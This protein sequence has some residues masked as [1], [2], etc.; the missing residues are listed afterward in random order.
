MSPAQPEVHRSGRTPLDPDHVDTTVEVEPRAPAEEPGGGPVPDANRPGRHPETEQD[1]P[2]LD[3]F[4]ERFGTTP[5]PDEPAEGA[6]DDVDPGNGTTDPPATGQ[7]EADDAPGSGTTPHPQDP[8]EG[9][10]DA[11][12]E[13]LSGE[14]SRPDADARSA[15]RGSG[16][17]PGSR[18]EAAASLV[19]TVVSLAGTA[20]STGVTVGVR[21]AR[22]VVVAA[23]N[24]T[25]DVLR[26]VR[27]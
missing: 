12:D 13:S 15:G 23:A 14:R 18:T 11:V 27:R 6:P 9:A 19:H 10:P 20:I 8:A 3:A 26:K 4:A 5:R 21:V 2:D 1:K 7:P 24:T 16:S 25:K 22:P 17:E